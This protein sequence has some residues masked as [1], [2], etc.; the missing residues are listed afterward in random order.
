MFMKAPPTVKS[1]GTRET[2]VYEEMTPADF[3]RD[4]P[5]R[6]E[7]ECFDYINKDVKEVVSAQ[8]ENGKKI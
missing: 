3:I 4:Y 8:N 1:L 2:S 7:A 6:L 5:G